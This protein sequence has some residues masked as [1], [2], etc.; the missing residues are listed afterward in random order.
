ML[1]PISALV[2]TRNRSLPLTRMLKSLAKQ[3]SQPQEIIIVDGSNNDATE[4]LCHHE[5]AN[6]E[7]EI[8][9]HR[10][11]TV[12]AATQR[13][14]ALTHATQDT[15]W[16]L[17]DDIILES[18]CLERL[19]LALNSDRRIGGVNAMI[20]NQKYLP[21]GKISKHLFRFLHSRSEP[22]YAG[23]CI[24]PG[25]NLLPEDNPDLPS[26]VPVEWLNTTCVLYR[27]EALPQPMFAS[28]F[29]G[30]SL[31]E[32]VTLSLTVGKQWKLV[33]AR[34]ARIFHDS[35]PGDHKNNPSVLAQMDLVNRHYVM[36]QILAKETLQD[37]LKLTILQLFGIAASLVSFRGWLNL[38]AILW[39]KLRAI[40]EI[41]TTD[42]TR[43]ERQ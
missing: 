29:T 24:G 21:P 25:L 15:I 3:T 13:N 4:Q 22:S 37:Y 12:G 26:V 34:T 35:Q 28:F 14:Q 20:T 30:Y 42:Y 6:L 18:N 23:K 10:A 7:S 32:D 38:P 2:A 43:L 11:T 36:T 17:D 16:L 39:G 40:A 8:I 19:W 31:L 9:Y 33:N 1:L 5:I 41:M 27:R